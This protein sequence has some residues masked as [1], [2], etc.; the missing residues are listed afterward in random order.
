MRKRFG[1]A[2]AV[3]ML[4]MSAVGA[5]AMPAIPGPVT[6]DAP[7]VTLVAD[8]CGPFAHRSHYGY[9]KSDGDGYYGGGP[10]FYRT[11][12]IYAPE[13]YYARRCFVQETYYGPRRICR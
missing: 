9:C 5:E 6:S 4:G 11:P 8:G 1:L 13:P 10:R 2:A 12:R 7:A 3:V